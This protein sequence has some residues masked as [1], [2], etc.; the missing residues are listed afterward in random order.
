MNII[1]NVPSD[2]FQPCNGNHKNLCGSIKIERQKKPLKFPKNCPL[3]YDISFCIHY[4]WFT[5]V[6][7]IIGHLDPFLFLLSFWYDV[8]FFCALCWFWQKALFATLLV[9]HCTSLTQCIQIYWCQRKKERNIKNSQI[10]SKRHHSILK[11]KS[12]KIT[13][14]WRAFKVNKMKI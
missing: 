5:T 7:A 14:C 3:K 12:T 1:H 10:Q 6:F 11:N 13:K 8:P 4:F 2:I 9:P